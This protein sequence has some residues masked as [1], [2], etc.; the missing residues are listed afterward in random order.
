MSS[1]KEIHLENQ[2]ILERISEIIDQNE[3]LNGFKRNHELE[4]QVWVKE[5]AK[6]EETVKKEKSKHEEAMKEKK[7]Q[8]RE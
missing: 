3:Q 6:Y 8:R 7:Q 5:K 1:S 4:R 2:R